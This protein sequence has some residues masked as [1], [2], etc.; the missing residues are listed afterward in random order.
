MKIC[1]EE[2]TAGFEVRLQA[3]DRG[4]FDWLLGEFKRW[5]PLRCRRYTDGRWLVERRVARTLNAWLAAMIEAGVEVAREADAA[6]RADAPAADLDRLARL[7]AEL[8]LV[9]GAPVKL[10][11]AARKILAV[12]HHPDKGGDEERM[13][14]INVAADLI[15]QIERCRRSAA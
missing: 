8:F 12:E 9:P 13:K 7:Y 14:R 6:P 5:V 15:M 4:Q 3:D 10:I 1:V 11:E 2:S